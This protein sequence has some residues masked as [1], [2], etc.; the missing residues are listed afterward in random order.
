MVDEERVSRIEEWINRTGPFTVQR[1]GYAS[2]VLILCSYSCFIWFSFVT[3]KDNRGG[4]C[5]S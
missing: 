3:I 2:M 1:S 4:H 5:L